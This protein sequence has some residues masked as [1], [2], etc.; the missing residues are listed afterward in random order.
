MGDGSEL[1]S[2]LRPKNFSF[3]SHF[4][5]KL[6][7]TPLLVVQSGRNIVF[8]RADDSIIVDEFFEKEA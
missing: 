4:T 5:L 7:E 2:L 1:I 8:L 6:N 3:P